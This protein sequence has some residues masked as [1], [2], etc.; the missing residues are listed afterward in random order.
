MS[1]PYVVVQIF[2]PMVPYV[3][4]N[5]PLVRQNALSPQQWKELMYPC[6]SEATIDYD[7]DTES[8]C[9]SEQVF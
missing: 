7:S 1:A 4:S 8:T 2:E 3:P 5:Y 6:P 9:T